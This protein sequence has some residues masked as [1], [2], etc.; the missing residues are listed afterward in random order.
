LAEKATRKEFFYYEYFLLP[1]R[2]ID[3][4]EVFIVSQPVVKI[5]HVKNTSP[6]LVVRCPTRWTSV[7]PQVF[8]LLG[9]LTGAT[10]VGQTGGAGIRCW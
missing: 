10:V 9:D 3:F 8:R 2:C 4:L 6:S 1:S 7:F 5:E